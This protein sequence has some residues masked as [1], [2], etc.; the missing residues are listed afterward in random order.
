MKQAMMLGILT[1]L[2]MTLLTACGNSAESNHSQ[3]VQDMTVEIANY[4]K[5]HA[6][7]GGSAGA[8][9]AAW[10]G[11][12]GLAAFGAEDIPKPSAVIMQYTGLSEYGEGDPADARYGF[13]IVR[14]RKCQECTAQRCAGK[15]CKERNPAYQ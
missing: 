10:V 9:M 15:Q 14:M 3:E 13:C 1:V 6:A 7:W 11:S 5:E 12:H 4:M 8:R 2:F